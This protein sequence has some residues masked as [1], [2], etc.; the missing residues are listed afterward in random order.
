MPSL[1][2]VTVP[3]PYVSLGLPR[4]YKSGLIADEQRNTVIQNVGPRRGELRMRNASLDGGFPGTV[5]RIPAPA[6]TQ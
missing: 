4:F 5:V 2:K 3:R 1:A 6:A